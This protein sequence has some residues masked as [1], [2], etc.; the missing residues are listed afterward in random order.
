ML[1]PDVAQKAYWAKLAAKKSILSHI[2][3]TLAELDATEKFSDFLLVVKVEHEMELSIVSEEL[4]CI[5][6][7]VVGQGIDIDDHV[8]FSH[9]VYAEELVM[10]TMAN[11][12]LHQLSMMQRRQMMFAS[13]SDRTSTSDGDKSKS[14]DSSEVDPTELDRYDD[15]K[16]NEWFCHNVLRVSDHA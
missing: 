9:A 8:A 6:D 2:N 10:L 13:D 3:T 4:Q 11:M 15:V 1:S 14:C 12:Q 5:K 7:I 16:Y